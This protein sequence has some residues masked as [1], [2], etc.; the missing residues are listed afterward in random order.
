VRFAASTAQTIA[1][2][3]TSNANRM[4]PIRAHRILLMPI[5]PR[6]PASVFDRGRLRYAD[7]KIVAHYLCRA[8]QN[9]CECI[10][11]WYTIDVGTTDGEKPMESTIKQV[12]FIVGKRFISGVLKGIEIQDDTT[13]EFEV[14]KTYKGIMGTSSYLVTSCIRKDA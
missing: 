7:A 5:P 13:V 4:S 2:I 10:S 11:I 8:S 3:P 12:R 6:R 9:A 14:G 1:P